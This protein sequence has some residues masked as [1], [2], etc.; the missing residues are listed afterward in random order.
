MTKLEDIVIK[1]KDRGLQEYLTELVALWNRGKYSFQKIGA[2]PTDTPSDV[3]IRVFDSGAGAVRIYVFVPGS[4]Q[5]GSG[6]WKT[7]NLSEV[8]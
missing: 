6:W 8:T 4:A 3:E 7:A 5:A 2:E 1:T